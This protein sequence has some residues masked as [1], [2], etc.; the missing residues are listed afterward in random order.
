[1]EVGLEQLIDAAATHEDTGRVAG[2]PRVDNPA[3]RRKSVPPEPGEP[4]LLGESAPVMAGGLRRRLLQREN[5]RQRRL[6][7][8][9][10]LVATG[11]DA[12]KALLDSGYSGRAGS[13]NISEACSVMLKHPDVISEVERLRLV[14]EQ[15]ADV[16]TI[17]LAKEWVSIASSDIFDYFDEVDDGDGVRLALKPKAEISK[18]A[19]RSVKAVKIRRNKRTTKDGDQIE[20]EDIEVQLWDKHSALDSLAKIQGLYQD[21]KADAINNLA[22]KIAERTEKARRRMGRTFDAGALEGPG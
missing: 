5:A 16:A 11:W 13:R 22:S 19:R 20:T 3:L 10:V 17:D 2:Q 21:K 18:A 14:L 1:M 6:H 12:E 8:A 4:E 7:F 15:Q 9:R